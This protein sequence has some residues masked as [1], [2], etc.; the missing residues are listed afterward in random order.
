MEIKK[1]FVVG[2]GLMGSGIAQVSAQA[3]YTVIIQDV[4]EESLKKGLESIRWSVK[5]FYEK[6]TI[7]ETPEVVL[8][9]ITP[10]KDRHAGKDADLVI[11]AVFERM[12]VKQEVFKELDVLCKPEAILATNSSALPITEIA[13]VTRRPEKVVGT[14]F[15]SPVPMMRIVEIVKGL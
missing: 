14:H 12:D 5:K 7:K 1:I 13:S 2:G 15:F 8:G 6:G 9:R 3:G 10:T 11:E 4:S